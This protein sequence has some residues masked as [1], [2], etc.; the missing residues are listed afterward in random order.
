LP[1]L[2]AGAQELPSRIRA[3]DFPFARNIALGGG[4]VG[5]GGDFS[6]LFTNP[7]AFVGVESQKSIS[8]FVID[9]ISVDFIFSMITS[10]NPLN[11]LVPFLAH[12]FEA[13]MDAAG[14]LAYGKTGGNHGWGLF[15]VT[16]FGMFWDRDEIY[17]I[18]LTLTEEFTF[19]GAYGFRLYNGPDARFDAGL[20]AKLFVRIG[21]NSPPIF[22]QQLRYLFQELVDGP[23]ETQFGAGVDI[24]LRWTLYDTL[25]FAAVVY[26]PFSPVW[27]T[28]YSRVEKIASQEM[29][30]QGVA[31][32]SPRASAGLSWKMVSPFWHRYFSDITFSLDYLGILGN[33]SERRRNPLLDL[34]AGLEV[35]M[36]EVFTLRGGLRDMLPSGGVGMN[37]SFMNV[38]IAFYGKELGTEPYQYTTWAITLDFSFRR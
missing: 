19:A 6:S 22:L 4:H 16:R 18:S 30:A 35:R 3:V 34:S 5:L 31:P 13:D 36:L 29:I 27:V 2:S 8:E 26:D 17:K 10:S 9:M 37:Y 23:F 1:V 12:S 33:L 7:A 25:S 32:V 11:E 28:Q 15:N 24:G 14:P 38:D 21:Y 20:T